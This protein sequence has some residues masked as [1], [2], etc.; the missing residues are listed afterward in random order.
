MSRIISI[1][2]A[3]VGLLLGYKVARDTGN[4]Q[5][6]GVILAACGLV[7]FTVWNNDAGSARGAPLTGMYL[8]TFAASHPLAKRIGQGPA[9]LTVTRVM[10]LASM[11]SGG[12]RKKDLGALESRQLRSLAD[13]RGIR[14]GEATSRPRMFRP[15]QILFVA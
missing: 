11:I 10:A 5:A 7:A 9:V 12:N 14:K 13:V 2:L 3:M 6:D 1:G 8:T 15:S 4:R